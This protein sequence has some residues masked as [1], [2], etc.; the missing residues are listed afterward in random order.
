MTHALDFNMLFSLLTLMGGGGVVVWWIKGMAERARVKNENIALMAKI[1]SDR[2]TAVA[3][4]EDTLRAEATEWI[5][6]FREEIRSLKDQL[7]KREAEAHLRDKELQRITQENAR[8]GD[9]LDTI[10]FILGAVME[11]LEGISPGNK[12]LVV[13]RTMLARA[14]REPHHPSNSATLNKAED[15]VVAARETVVEIKAAEAKDN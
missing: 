3:R 4:I 7:A 6:K 5:A 10:M 1:E 12:T 2:A 13:M 9:K 11:E 8:R 15:A 14:G